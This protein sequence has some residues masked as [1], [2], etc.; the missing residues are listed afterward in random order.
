MNALPFDPAAW[1]VIYR[2]GAPPSAWTDFRPTI[3][4]AVI[5]RV[6]AD[7]DA[8]EYAYPSLPVQQLQLDLEDARKLAEARLAEMLSLQSQRNDA[9]QEIDLIT[10]ALPRMEERSLMADTIERAV[11]YTRGRVSWRTQDDEVMHRAAATLR[12]LPET[13]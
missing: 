4:P 11:S 8:V 7:G 1:R 12:S 6:E 2:D 9:L 13:E 5:Q 10:E 3:C